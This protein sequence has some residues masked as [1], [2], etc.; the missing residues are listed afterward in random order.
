MVIK[1]EKLVQLEGKIGIDAEGKSHKHKGKE[2][3]SQNTREKP[4]KNSNSLTEAEESAIPKFQKSKG[5]VANVM[6]S[7]LQYGKESKGDKSTLR[8]IQTDYQHVS[9]IQDAIN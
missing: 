8:Q 2:K 4:E 9:K 5:N 6:F 7:V 3:T 1:F